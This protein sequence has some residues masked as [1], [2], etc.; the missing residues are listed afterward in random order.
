VLRRLFHQ[1]R[2]P[3]TALKPYFGH[4]VT[5]SALIELS[6]LLSSLK[7]REIPPIPTTSPEEV[8]PS[9][10]HLNL[11]L[12]RPIPFTGKYILSLAAGFGGFF[13]SAVLEVWP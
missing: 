5:A 13:S 10:S 4:T 2:P 12:E 7:N 3:V 1:K 9:C 8:D 6:L 11:A